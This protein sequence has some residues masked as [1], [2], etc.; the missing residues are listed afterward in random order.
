MN[1]IAFE[2]SAHLATHQQLLINMAMRQAFFA[3]QLPVLELAEW[4]AAEIESN[5]VLESTPAPVETSFA[6]R[7]ME[8][9]RT[10]F[11]HQMPAPISLY[12]HLQA[13][14]QLHFC[15]KE[16][17]ALAEWILGHLDE[18][19]FLGVPLGELALEY[20]MDQ[21]QEILFALQTFDPPG[22]AATSL[23]DSLLIQ[24]QLK[25]KASLPAYRIIADHF[26]DLLHNRLPLIS[27]QLKLS[28][29]ELRRIIDEE[30]VPLDLHP[31]YRFLPHHH[32]RLIADLTLD[33]MEDTWKVEVT[34]SY[35]PGFHIAPVYKQALQEKSIEGE[36]AAYL[37]R[38]MAG[39]SWLKRIIAK[40]AETLYQLGK[41]LV[42]HQ[43]AFLQGGELSPMRVA[44]AAQVLHLS[45]STVARAI[46]NKHVGT[47]RGIFA[48]RDFFTQGISQASGES[49]SNHTLRE[50]LKQLV[51]QE[52]RSQPLS[53]E[54]IAK[55]LGAEGYACARRTITKYRK[56][57]N[58]PS[59]AQRRAWK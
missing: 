26:D 14:A 53:D 10:A 2:Q 13:Q 56:Q 43:S 48:M 12:A 21:L 50:R 4:L 40:R 46:A 58:I 16:D 31:G 35:L 15:K 19:G 54:M 45:E 11:E 59:T 3:M 27:K 7:K 30:I 23:K 57:L 24:L 39:G 18:R 52:D 17:L 8:E 36:D 6:K 49:V 51:E 42:K 37:R 29:G 5:P 47:P 33:W 55:K 38:Q 34:H 25:G 32:A 28:L 20:P 1:N 9:P 22:I 44:Q 41:F